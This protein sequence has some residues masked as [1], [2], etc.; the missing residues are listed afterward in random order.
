MFLFERAQA[1]KGKNREGG[2]GRNFRQE[3]YAGRVLVREE[4]HLRGLRLGLWVG[5]AFCLLYCV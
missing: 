5:K 2:P 1:A 4:G 3:I